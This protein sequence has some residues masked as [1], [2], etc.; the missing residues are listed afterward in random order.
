MSARLV[1]EWRTALLAN[2]V[3]T[4]VAAKT[5]RLLRAI[6]TAADGDDMLNR[7]PC[8]IK[9]GGDEDAGEHPV[10]T[11]RQIFDLRH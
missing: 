9:G 11:V 7:S 1:R 3:S 5:Y 4:S 8:R 6:M 2:G 10:L